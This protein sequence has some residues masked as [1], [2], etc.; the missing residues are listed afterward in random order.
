MSNA[1]QRWI[2]AAGSIAWAL[3]VLVLGVALVQAAGGFGDNAAFWLPYPYPRPGSEGLM[4]Y[5]TLL[6]RRGESLYGPITPDRFISGPYPPI[7]YLLAGWLLPPGGAGFSEGRTL[8]LW[9]AL[10]V[11][12]ALVLLV[13]VGGWGVGGG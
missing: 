5:E 1:G 12:A 6:M 13:G 9:A 3:G 11:A 8:S 10:V 2:S 7:Y 4:L